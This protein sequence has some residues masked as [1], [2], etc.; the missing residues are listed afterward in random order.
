MKPICRFL[1]KPNSMTCLLFCCAVLNFSSWPSS[2]ATATFA[3]FFPFVFFLPFQ[4]EGLNPCVHAQILALLSLKTLSAH[5]QKGPC[6]LSNMLR[7][8]SDLNL[9]SQIHSCMFRR[10][11]LW[12]LILHIDKTPAPVFSIVCSWIFAIKP[13]QNRDKS[14]HHESSTCRLWF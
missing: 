6:F 11:A 4:F 9:W 5:I 14:Q 3:P 13:S 1:K 8:T 12:V 2:E 7:S 10:P